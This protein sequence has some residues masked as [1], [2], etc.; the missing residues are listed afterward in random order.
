MRVG[1]LRL[2]VVAFLYYCHLVPHLDL[3]AP[4][5]QISL[6]LSL[7]PLASFVAYPSSTL[8]H[9]V[10][11]PIFSRRFLA[12]D[13]LYFAVAFYSYMPF[14][15][16]MV[17]GRLDLGNG[18]PYPYASLVSRRHAASRRALSCS[19]DKHVIKFTMRLRRGMHAWEGFIETLVLRSQRDGWFRVVVTR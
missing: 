13:A 6:D 15:C 8:A 10:L 11:S 3:V 16:T 12:R 7:C 1:L 2:I 17:A 19:N 4:S 14:V 5:S 9:I 18:S